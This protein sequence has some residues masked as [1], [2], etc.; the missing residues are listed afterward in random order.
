M[1]KGNILLRF[2]IDHGVHGDYEKIADLSSHFELAAPDGMAISED[3]RKFLLFLG[4]VYC[5]CSI[6]MAK[7]WVLYLPVPEQPTVY[8]QPTTKCF[9]SPLMENC[10]G[11]LFRTKSTK[12]FKCILYFS[13]FRVEKEMSLIFI[14]IFDT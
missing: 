10:C 12:C 2:S 1:P 4:Q 6:R 5:L 3:G 8:L 11:W 13:L 9:I 7:P 14:C